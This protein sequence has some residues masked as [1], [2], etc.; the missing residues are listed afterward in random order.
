[1]KLVHYQNRKLP[2]IVVHGTQEQVDE[3]II[4]NGLVVD[5]KISPE[6]YY[7]SQQTDIESNQNRGYDH[8]NIH[9]DGDKFFNIY[10]RAEDIID[11]VC[12][13]NW[14]W[15]NDGEN[16]D[17]DVIAFSKLLYES[18]GYM[19]RISFLSVPIWDSEDTCDRIFYDDLNNYEL[20]DVFLQRKMR[21]VIE[22]LN[23]HIS[24]NSPFFKN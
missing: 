24:L 10:D 7:I 20:M 11:I 5:S 12:E 8:Y 13:M 14:K 17:T 1:M 6:K 15:E 4:S 23:S 19:Q 22:T 2:V 18:D 3:Y 21:E 16:L 9:A